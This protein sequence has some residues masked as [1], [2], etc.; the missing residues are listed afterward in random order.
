MGSDSALA[1][2]LRRILP[3]EANGASRPDCVGVMAHGGHAEATGKGE[4]RRQAG[5]RQRSGGQCSGGQ[6]S[7]GQCS[8][9][10]AVWRSV[11]GVK[12]SRR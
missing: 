8:G 4:D 11:L 7:G 5:G 6:C 10:S 9:G 2:S 12:R 1:P 3:A